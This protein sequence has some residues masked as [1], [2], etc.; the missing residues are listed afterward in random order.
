MTLSQKMG[1]A[2]DKMNARVDVLGPVDAPVDQ[3]LIRLINRLEENGDGLASRQWEMI[4]RLMLRVE[5]LER[6]VTTPI[7]E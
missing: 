6:A 1:E 5:R 4:R 7:A 2:F 3:A